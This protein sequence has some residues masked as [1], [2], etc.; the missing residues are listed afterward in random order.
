MTR[1]TP[2]AINMLATNLAPMATRGLSFLSWRAKPK[3]GITATMRLALARLAASININNSNK[4]SEGG[5]VDWT[6]I[7]SL[8]RTVS[9]ML[10]ANSPSENFCVRTGTRE[11]P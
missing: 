5:K 3:Y 11:V 6:M 4:L 10:T 9:S 2:A 8:P 7:T 1:F